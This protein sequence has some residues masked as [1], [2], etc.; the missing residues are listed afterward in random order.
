M[1]AV[2][3]NNVEC[4][5]LLC[6]AKANLNQTDYKENTALHTALKLNRNDCLKVLLSDK[7]TNDSN[8]KIERETALHIAVTQ[9]N[10]HGVRQLVAAGADVNLK[11][12][13]AGQTPLHLAVEFDSPEIVNYLLCQ[14]RLQLHFLYSRGLYW[15]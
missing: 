4:L 13:T 14:V 12:G 10:L 8:G 1:V 6:M 5:K 15:I 11:T 2:E 7:P 3:E 9:K